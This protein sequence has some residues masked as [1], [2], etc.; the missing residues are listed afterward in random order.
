MTES[1][2]KVTVYGKDKH[3][4][5]NYGKVRLISEKTSCKWSYVRRRR[6]WRFLR[7][8]IE[9]ISGRLLKQILKRGICCQQL[10]VAATALWFGGA[11]HQ[12]ILCKNILPS[13]QKLSFD[14]GWISN[15]FSDPKHQKKSIKGVWKQNQFWP[16]E[17]LD[18][19]ENLW[20]NLKKTVHDRNKL[21]LTNC[22]HFAK[23]NVQI[24]TP[25]SAINLLKMI[26]NDWSTY[27]R[28]KAEPPNRYM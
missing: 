28:R 7:R 2:T 24:L 23:K 13:F 11:W 12:A 6:N 8:M 15:S 10:N 1:L 16:S 4:R 22:E 9:S 3:D 26:E 27:S 21:N 19:N 20:S 14:K 5:L 25:T 17:I 18:P